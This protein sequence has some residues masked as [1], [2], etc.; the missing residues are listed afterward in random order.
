[1]TDQPSFQE[2]KTEIK[3]YLLEWIRNSQLSVVEFLS[4]FIG[5]SVALLMS[6][7]FAF[8]AI[9]FFS[10]L[11][12]SWLGSYFEEAYLGLAIVGGF[13]FLLFILFRTVLRKGLNR[14]FINRM[15]KLF[16]TILSYHDKKSD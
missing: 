14:F 4:R 1:M 13:Y 8:L 12:S 3:A 16:T 9:V 5:I 2:I 6:I 7:G 15:V 11:L 10:F